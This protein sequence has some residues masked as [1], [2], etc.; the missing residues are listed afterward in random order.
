[1]VGAVKDM[2]TLDNPALTEF[3]VGEFGTEA[4]ET[5]P[6]PLY[7]CI[8]P[9][10]IQSVHHICNPAT[11]VLM[12]PRCDLVI[13]GSSNPLLVLSNSNKAQLLMVVAL[14]PIFN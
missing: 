9:L 5:Q 13:R 6:V 1:L 3:M 11:G 2:V 8:S 12:L 14:P 4:N 7:N 10:A